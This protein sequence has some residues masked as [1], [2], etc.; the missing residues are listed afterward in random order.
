ML[1][2]ST[3]T[4]KNQTTLPKAVVAALGVKP[5]DKL[6]YEIEGGTI[7]LR[8]RTG[9]LLDLVGKFAHV[10]FRPKKPLTKQQL[11]AA[12]GDHLAEDD[13]R[14]RR[15]WHEARRKETRAAGK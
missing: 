1:A 15:Q 11:R 3:L 6:L 12:I 8:A 14:I 7:I 13:A 4:S 2:T 5:A 9:R 10:G